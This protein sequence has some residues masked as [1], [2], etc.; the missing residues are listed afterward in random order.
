MVNPVSNAQ[1]AST[2]APLTNNGGFEELTLDPS[3]PYY[4]HPS[5]SPS[6]Q[7]VHVI[8]NDNGFAIW[9]NSIITSPSAKNKLG[10]V[11]GRFPRPDSNNPYFHFW[12]RYD[13]MVKGLDH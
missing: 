10:M 2:S 7:L 6:F 8:F 1:H 4:I 9:R 13:H 12:E 5:E 3:H 11:N